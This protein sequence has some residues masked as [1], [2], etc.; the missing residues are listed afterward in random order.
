MNIYSEKTSLWKDPELLAHFFASK[1]GEEGLS[2]LDSDESEN[3]VWSIL[4]I[5]PK[6]VISCIN[7][8]IR[9]KETSSKSS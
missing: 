3:G 4:G 7:N 6:E 9:A 1:F 5:N 2:W 8:N